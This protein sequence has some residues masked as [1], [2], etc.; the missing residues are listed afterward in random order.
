[1]IKYWS[2]IWKYILSSN[3]FYSYKGIMKEKSCS[4][5]KRMFHEIKAS[6]VRGVL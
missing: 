6:E 5:L 1:M 4:I 2:S 3:I